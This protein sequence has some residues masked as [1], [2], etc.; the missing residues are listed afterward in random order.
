MT[1]VQTCALPIWSYFSVQNRRKPSV[2]TWRSQGS[3]DRLVERADCI[4]VFHGTSLQSLFGIVQKGIKP[5]LGA[6][7][8][9]MKYVYGF[10]VPGTQ[11]AEAGR[12]FLD[13]LTTSEARVLLRE[14]GIETG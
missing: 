8:D 4:E 7:Q 9:A 3:E 13:F 5:T 6:G 11:N 14:A 12:A 2:R 1:G 10:L